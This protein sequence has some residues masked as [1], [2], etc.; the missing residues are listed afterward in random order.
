MTRK[1][2][3]KKFFVRPT[4]DVA[5]DLLGKFL[6]R[7]NSPLGRGGP[8]LA[9]ATGWVRGR[10]VLKNNKNEVAVMITEVEA[11]DGPHDRASHASRGMTERN[12]IMFGQGGYFYVYLCYGMYEML[13]IV[14]GPKNYPAAILLRGASP[15]LPKEGVG[16]GLING[17]GKLTKFLKINRSFNKKPASKKT[18]LWFEDRGVEISAK[19][20]KRTPRVGVAYAGP[21][22]S[23]KKYRFL[24]TNV[25][26]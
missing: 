2:L 12:A 9:G 18:N 6:V 5:C 26:K 15:L 21:V 11:Y 13:N 4:L 1:I 7:K 14:T 23:K 17:P 24:L 16:G 3:Q 19:M 10:G 8:A 25:E 22:W 20:I